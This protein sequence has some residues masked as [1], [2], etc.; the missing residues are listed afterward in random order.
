MENLPVAVVHPFEHAL[1]H[2]VELRADAAA[3]IGGRREHQQPR[4]EDRHQRHRDEERHRQREDDD[5]RQLPEHDARDALEEQ[6]RH[7]HRDV[8]ED[9]RENRRPHFLAAVDRRRHPILAVVFHVA[10]RVLEHHDRGVDHHPDAE[11]QPAERHRVQRQAAE[12]EQ[13]ERADHRDRNRGAD[14]ERRAEIP[15][16]EKDD[17]DDEDRADHHVLLDRVDRALDELRAVVEQRQP[18]ARAPHG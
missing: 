15:Q 3:L 10:E 2:P 6:Q 5:D 12:V 18:D 4:A 9:R 11:R 7:E 17:A 13:R 1:A 14:D 16:E 8:R